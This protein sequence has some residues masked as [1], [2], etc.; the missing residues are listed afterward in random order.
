MRSTGLLTP[1]DAINRIRYR[2]ASDATSGNNLIE[3]WEYPIPKLC[4]INGDIHMPHAGVIRYN[5]RNI[6]THTRL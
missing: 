2:A 4:V 1:Y 6:V 5:I 3:D